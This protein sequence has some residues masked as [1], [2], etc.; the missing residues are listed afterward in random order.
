MEHNIKLDTTGEWLVIGNKPHK[1]PKKLVAENVKGQTFFIQHAF[2]FLEKA[3]LV[4][5]NKQLFLAPVPIQNELAYIGTN[6]L[7][8]PTLGVY[9]EWWLNGKG[10]IT[11]DNEGLPALTYQFSGSLLSGVNYCKCVYPDGQTKTI[12]HR[13]FSSIWMG[14]AE[15]NQR[16]TKAKQLFKAFNIKDAYRYLHE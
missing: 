7:S 5:Q 11:T 9:L 1:R 14:F 2:F 13:D 3:E 10:N 16:Y 15:I 6:G 4:F 8:N 12:T